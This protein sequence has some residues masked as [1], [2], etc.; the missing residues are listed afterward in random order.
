MLPSNAMTVVRSLLVVALLLTGCSK[1]D[2]PGPSCDQ[3][4]THLLE[5]T[6]IAYPGHAGMGEMGDRK[7]MIEQCE[8][9]HLTA[10]QR[11][12]LVAAK[13]LDGLAGCYPKPAGSPAA[14]PK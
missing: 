9:K 7:T 12:C 14:A 6:K 10:D 5:V 4:V 8:Q 1:K 13:D 3:V 2:D 11:R